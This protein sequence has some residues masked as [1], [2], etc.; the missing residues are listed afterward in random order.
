MCSK[1]LWVPGEQQD[2]QVLRS[3]GLSGTHGVDQTSLELTEICMPL[4]SEYL[5]YT[6]MTS[7]TRTW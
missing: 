1:G 4:P 2:A 7:S 6:V 3:P 5:A